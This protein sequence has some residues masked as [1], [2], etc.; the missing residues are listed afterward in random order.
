MDELNEEKMMETEGGACLN[1]YNM[2]NMNMKQFVLSI[3]D[4]KS[5]DKR[6]LYITRV[7][8]NGKCKEVQKYVGASREFSWTDFSELHK[9]KIKKQISDKWRYDIFVNSPY[10]SAIKFKAVKMDSRG[11]PTYLP[12]VAYSF[13]NKRFI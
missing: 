6:D 7:W 8:I 2:Y 9:I 4:E 12:E 13:K 10:I 5:N 11:I 3:A 1:K